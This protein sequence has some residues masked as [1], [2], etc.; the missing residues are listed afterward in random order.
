MGM[1]DLTIPK[2]I[3][4]FSGYTLLVLT[5]AFIPLSKTVYGASTANFKAGEIIDDSVFTDYSS[6]NPSQIQAFLNSKVPVC[7]TNGTQVSEYGGGTRAQWGQANYGQ[8]TFTCLKDYTENGLSSAQIIYNTAQKYQ[9][10]PQVL[11]VLLQK[12]QGLVTDTWPLNI[13]YQTATGYG[14]PDTASCD[15]QYYGLTNQLDWSGK[16]FRAV[17]N[18][19]ATW[20]SPYVMGSNY[21]QWNPNSSCGGTNVNLANMPTVALYDYTPYQPNQAALNA[22]YGTGD[23]CS[24]YGNRNFYLYFTD[25]FGSTYTTTCTTSEVP[26]PQVDSYYNPKTGDH[27]Y[28]PYYCEGNVLRLQLGYYDEGAVFNTTDKTNPNAVPVYRL[29]NPQTTQHLWTTSQDEINSAQQLAGYHLEGAAFYTAPSDGVGVQP[30]YRL[31]NPRTFQHVWTPNLVVA[32]F[33]AQNV[34]FRFEGAAFY[35]Q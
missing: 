33:I 25:W 7:D 2:K 5:L 16:M 29:Y 23:S 19:S 14:C 28:T 27:F 15:T 17:L 20:Y 4:R 26:D 10:N 12:E 32:N 34:G 6:M 1:K 31:Y 30:V 21:I 3:A 24:S 22:G 18:K 11:I 35:S 13:Q 8:S 9:I